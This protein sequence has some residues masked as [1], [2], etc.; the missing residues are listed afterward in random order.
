[1]VNFDGKHWIGKKYLDDPMKIHSY[2]HVAKIANGRLGDDGIVAIPNATPDD[3]RYEEFFHRAK[4]EAKIESIEDKKAFYDSSKRIYFMK[5][6]EVNTELDGIPITFL[7]YNIPFNQ[8]LEDRNADQVLRDANELKCIVGITGPSCI[9][10]LEQALRIKP[11]LLGHLDFFVGY[12]SSAA[13]KLG[14]NDES[15][16]F[17][18]KRIN[19]RKFENPLTKEEE[20]KVGFTAVS[21]GH[22]TPRG[23]VNLIFGQTI[24]K[25]YVEINSPSHENFMGDLRTSLRDATFYDTYREPIF[26]ESI[27]HVL[28]MGVVD[29]LR[30][31]RKSFK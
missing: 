28:S 11:D 24:G 6:Q 26:L 15:M 14:V 31:F 19:N 1:M 8:Y 20:H 21:G 30:K 25:S 12:G 22:R 18:D 27:R 7:V 23:L 4:S 13:P 9:K 29:K 3:R 10:G 5:A 2:N 17:Y 16:I